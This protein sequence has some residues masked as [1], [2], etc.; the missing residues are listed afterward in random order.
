MAETLVQATNVFHQTMEQAEGKQHALNYNL[1]RNN[2]LLADMETREKYEQDTD[3]QT[4]D[5]RYS[6]SYKSR[7]ESI[8]SSSNLS[9][10]D[11]SL[12]ESESAMIAAK[13]RI[14]MAARARAIEIDEGFTGMMRSVENLSQ[15]AANESAG[16][17]VR[18]VNSVLETIDSALEMGYFGLD[19]PETKAE[20]LRDETT[21]NI[22]RMSIG[23]MTND[24]KLRH[25]GAVLG[26][27]RG[28]GVGE[29]AD[30]VAQAAQK[31][32]IP[33]ELIVAQMMKESSG[34]PNAKSGA[35]GDPTGL[36]QIG[37]AAAKDMGITDRTDPEQSILGGAQYDANMLKRFG[38]DKAKALAAYNMGPG[39]L[40]KIIEK[41]GDG[42]FAYIN[43][44]EFD[45]TRET[46]KYVEKL[47][48]FWEGTAPPQEYL[49]ATNTGQGPLTREEVLGGKG[50]GLVGDFLHTD[51]LAKMYDE[52]YKE[53]KE[54]QERIQS[55][56]AVDKAYELFPEDHEKRIAFIEEN[57]S[58]AIR[59][60]AETDLDLKN[61][62]MER[63]KE[64]KATDVYNNYVQT[65]AEFADGE[66][67][68]EAVEQF[69]VDEIPQEHKDLMGAARLKALEN[70]VINRARNIQHPAV[71]QYVE[72]RDKN[73]KAITN[74][75]DPNFV[76]SLEGYLRLPDFGEGGKT[77]VDL[78]DDP[79][80]KQA[81]DRQ[82]YYALL[83]DQE[84]L[85]KLESAKIA[86]PN[87]GPLVVDA[88]RSV[89][90]GGVTNKRAQ[91]TMA[92]RMEMRLRGDIS[93]AQQAKV[94]PTKLTDSEIREILVGY[95]V[96]EAYYDETTAWVDWLNP[97][98]LR[99]DFAF[100][101]EQMKTAYLPI[102]DAK[103]QPYLGDDP[104]FKDLNMY[105][106]LRELSKT[107][108]GSP[109]DDE[110]I[111]RAYW[112]Y[113]R[114]LPDEEIESR[115]RGE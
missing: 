87:V 71:T 84:N 70:E 110:N 114:G 86:V 13:G 112:A 75:N 8:I 7:S 57:Y 4:L 67:D 40:E 107:L 108:K 58:G 88:L 45:P 20:A 37:E 81:F 49:T 18:A 50:T 111:A 98:N 6:E 60:K 53:N 38:G 51:E 104:A 52:A 16:N 12:I 55:Q 26:Y 69:S 36:M 74:V 39:K 47:L 2:L 42:W 63:A 11:R 43:S 5:K 46:A 93:R 97:D 35:F 9:P 56:A 76:A 41:H 30:I 64:Q 34:D 109:A 48:P 103:E 59:K 85:K 29:Y 91:N 101:A 33:P 105:E 92:A 31:Y 82:T 68:G 32:D 10:Y 19:S 14:D 90:W 44:T 79:M 77:S 73:G 83:E 1:A 100:T 3:W 65:I 17:R 22:A 99:Q 66:L 102:E 96:E 23:G 113:K 21:K 61:N 78:L 115:L 28:Y 72:A 25:I 89:D 15:V 27:R 95:M 80:W 62:R 24:E 94:P 106:F 54:E